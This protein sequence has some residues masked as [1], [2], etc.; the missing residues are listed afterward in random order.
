M[1]LT[2][3][4]DCTTCVMDG[5]VPVSVL[6]AVRETLTYNDPGAFF[7]WQYK[8]GYDDGKRC[9]LERQTF[10]AGLE[11]RVL[12]V[13]EGLVDVEIVDE[14]PVLWETP[15]EPVT[16]L[17][18]YRASEPEWINLE[19]DQVEAMRAFLDNPRGCLALPTSAGKTEIAAA[20]FK[21]LSDRRCLF[22][23]DRKGLL[24]QTH[25][26]LSGRLGE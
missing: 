25:E 24:S 21:T 9:L 22:I 2:F 5:R 15:P 6:Q 1:R 13:L 10:P 26:R 20:L 14:R 16:R 23:V 12:S 17:R 11:H 19:P 4:A 8:A 7:T 18:G 3:K